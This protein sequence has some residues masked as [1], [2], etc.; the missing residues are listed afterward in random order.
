[1]FLA[2]LYRAEQ[3]IAARLIRIVNGGLPWDC[4]TAPSSHVNLCH[5]R[6]K[7]DDCGRLASP[8]SEDD[9]F[10]EK[11]I[12]IGDHFHRAGSKHKSDLDKLLFDTASSERS[13]RSQA[14]GSN[15]LE[16][17]DRAFLEHTR[18]L[19]VDLDQEPF[20]EYWLH[21][22]HFV[23]VFSRVEGRLLAFLRNHTKAS[24]EVCAVLLSGI[25]VDGAKDYIN[26]VLDVPDRRI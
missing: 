21:L 3:A 12:K 8:G 2:G 9:V 7:L 20:D 1:V 14:S 24:A 16:F 22:G 5:V 19:I 10:R 18:R 13:N 26:K 6:C 17:D 15:S 11:P 25:R 4:L 23:H